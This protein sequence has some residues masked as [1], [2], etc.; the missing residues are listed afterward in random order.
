MNENNERRPPCK[1]ITKMLRNLSRQVNGAATT[2]G[3]GE[4]IFLS[5]WETTMNPEIE[6]MKVNIEDAERAEH[7]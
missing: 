6:I 2:G 5:T 7:I 1:K 4:M 3:L